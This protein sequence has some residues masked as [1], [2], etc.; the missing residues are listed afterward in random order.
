MKAE[1]QEKLIKDWTAYLAKMDG[2]KLGGK[3]RG[4]DREDRRG[5][6]Y[7]T[8]KQHKQSLAETGFIDKNAIVHVV[9]SRFF[10]AAGASR[11]RST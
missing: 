9:R 4:W 5:R 3:W 6:A 10:L 8:P 2:E 11:W 7:P 1:G